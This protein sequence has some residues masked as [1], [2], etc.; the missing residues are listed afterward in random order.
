[1]GG[2]N[3]HEQMAAFFHHHQQTQLNAQTQAQVA[4]IMAASGVGNGMI[5]NE[6]QASSQSLSAAQALTLMLKQQQAITNHQ[7]Q[8]QSMQAP[9]T[10]SPPQQMYQ[11]IQPDSSR[12][13]PLTAPSPQETKVVPVETK[14]PNT[15]VVQQPDQKVSP[16]PPKRK[17]V[18]NRVKKQKLQQQKE[19][20]VSVSSASSAPQTQQTKLALTPSF[21]QQTAPSPFQQH[22]QGLFQNNI[23]PIV[24]LQMRSWK[25]NQLGKLFM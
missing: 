10:N 9:V 8:Q 2:I 20:T 7:Q 18:C 22:G 4:A 1:M 25:L 19:T 14:T 5:I 13:E 17:K 24:L 21:S 23:S 6:G 16:S 15:T 3:M 11:I 12:I